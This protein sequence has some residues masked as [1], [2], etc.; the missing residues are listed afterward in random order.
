MILIV[1]ADDFGTSSFVNRGVLRGH[2]SGI[3]TSASLLVDHPAAEEAAALSQD[4]PALSVGLHL[5]LGEWRFRDGAWAPVYEVVDPG[6]ADAVNVECRRQLGRFRQLLDRDPTHLDSHQ[7]AHRRSPAREIVRDMGAELGIPVRHLTPGV[8]Y[9]GSFY[10]QTD[11]GERLLGRITVAALLSII[12]R[13]PDGITELGCHP[14]E[15][16]APGEGELDTMYREER[17][18]EL[19]VLC[20]PAVRAAIAG[21]GIVLGSFADLTGRAHARWGP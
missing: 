5:D 10:G 7:H 13:L 18:E 6:D 17:I 16:P 9:E 3:V 14:S 1:N 2:A 8:R 15:V 20:D 19:E 4:R 21:R 12:E 11:E